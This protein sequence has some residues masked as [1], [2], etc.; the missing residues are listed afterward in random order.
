[1]EWLFRYGGDAE[2]VPLYDC[3]T[4]DRKPG[5]TNYVIGTAFIVYGVIAELIYILDLMVMVKKQHRRLSC[6][7]IM[8]ALGIYDMAAISLNSLLTGYFWIKGTNYCVAPTLM[9]VTG[10]IALGKRSITNTVFIT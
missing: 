5:T 4:S 7:K 6:Y 3:K 2:N 9:Y 1:M 10:A 8:I